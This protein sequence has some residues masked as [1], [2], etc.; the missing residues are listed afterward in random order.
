[1]SS[2]V[3]AIV[4]FLF[5]ILIHEFGHF[6]IAKKSG[7]KVN[8]F[9]I[10]MGPKIYSK[11]KGE[12]TYSLNLLPIGG[13][14]AMEGE[15]DNSNDP[16]SFNNSKPSARF[17]TILAGPMTNFI[18]AA[19]IFAIVIG[20]IGV[21]TNKIGG[22]VENSKA[23]LSGIKENDRIIKIGD[24][25]IEQ[26]DQ[27]SPALNEFYKEA[28][29]NKEVP[30]TV[31]RKDKE[32][33]F[34]VKPDFKENIPFLGLSSKL[35]KVGFL[36]SIGLGFKEVWKNIKSIVGVFGAL[37][38]GAIGFSALSGPVGVVK[39]LGNQA[40]Q[41]IFNLLYFFAYISVNLGFFN[42]LP[43]PALDGSKILTSLYEMIS[44]K[45]V[46]RKIEQRATIVGFVLLL[47]LILVVT[48]KDVVTL[49]L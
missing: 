3:I 34:N 41:G 31:L 25:N 47:G 39:E 18:F 49:I 28:D 16:R 23:E 12:T 19:I 20:N 42:L 36:Q 46:N 37:F 44:G 26:F 27:V 8:E 14:C 29:Q 21:S 38:S 7:I 5:L 4:M 15:E 1:M 24:I 32:K 10:G 45:P 35:E 17:F 40:N 48:I 9:A 33:T 6:I 43:I 2:V 11:Q 22:F 30:I 13:Y